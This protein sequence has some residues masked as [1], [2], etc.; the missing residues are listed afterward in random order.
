MININTDA[1]KKAYMKAIAHLV[2]ERCKTDPYLSQKCSE[3]DITLE[4][5]YEYVKSEAKKQAVSGC[6]VL[7]DSEVLEMAVHF[8]MEGKAA[9]AEPVK[10]EVIEETPAPKEWKYSKPKKALSDEISDQL[11]FDF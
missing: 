9:T 4:D 7:T 8:I 10:E 11:A 3:S 1:Y 5:V 2:S 6:A